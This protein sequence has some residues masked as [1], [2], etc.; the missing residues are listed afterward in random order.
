MIAINNLTV[1]FGGFTLLD[2]INFH[3]S[4]GEHIALAGKNGAGKSTILKLIAGVQSPTGGSITKPNGITIGY[5]PQIMD[6]DKG[7]SVLDAAMS[8]F[9][10][11]YMMKERVEQITVELG[12]RSD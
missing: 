3:I 8:A 6:Y 2:N 11:M 7:T 1:A 12:Q 10:D 4:D 5:L 9:S